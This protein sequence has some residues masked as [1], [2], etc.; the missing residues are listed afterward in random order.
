MSTINPNIH[1]SKY[2]P[3]HSPHHTY[4]LPTTHRKYTHPFPIRNLPVP[5]YSFPPPPIPILL[6]LILPLLPYLQNLRKLPHLSNPHNPNLTLW[7]Y[8]RLPLPSTHHVCLFPPLLSLSL[9]PH[10]QPRVPFYPPPH[11][12]RLN[13]LL[14]LPL[15][16]P[17]PPGLPSELV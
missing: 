17:P 5:H 16:L 7:S 1:R 3:T 11:P 4:S 9:S 2:P 14:L 15:R 6:P 10:P 12:L 8:C 13:L